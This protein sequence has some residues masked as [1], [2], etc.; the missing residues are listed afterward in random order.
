MSKIPSALR[1]LVL[2]LSVTA[3]LLPPFLAPA[4]AEPPVKRIGYLEAGPYWVYKNIWNAFVN[5]MNEYDDMRCTFPQDARFSPGWDPD[6]TRGLP[7]KARELMGRKDLD[8]VVGMGTA[9]VKA[10]LAANDGRLPILGMGMAD[11][12]AAGVVASADDSGTDNFTC[13]VSVDRLSSM[14][15]AF[16]DV[17]RFKKLGIM[18]HDSLEGRTYTALDDAIAIASEMGFSLVIHDGL[19]AEESV[20]ECRKGLEDLRQRGMDA[21]FVAPL[22]CFEL[23]SDGLMPLLQTL[24]EWKIPTFSRGGSEH[25]KAGALMGVSTWDFDPVGTSLAEQAHAILDGAKPRSLPM[26]ERFEPSIALNLA[27]A[28]IIDFHFPFELLVAADELL[29]TI[30]PPGPPAH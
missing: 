26:R 11:P 15:R 3:L 12:V 9:A 22:N 8:L 10:L 18:Y 23:D 25:V 6:G 20:Q 14:F 16:H 29:E 21:F 27:V 13:R 19:S 24:M 30:T 2:I 1:L 5:A 7:E 4:L 17:V 28:K